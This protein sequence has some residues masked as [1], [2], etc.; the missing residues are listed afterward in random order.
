MRTYKRNER[1]IPYWI[2]VNSWGVDFGMNGNFLI[3]RG[4]NTCG[5]EDNIYT[6]TPK[7]PEQ[8]QLRERDRRK[9]ID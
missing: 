1:K 5:I 6:A 9:S 7:L 2:I 8:V 3:R 4:S